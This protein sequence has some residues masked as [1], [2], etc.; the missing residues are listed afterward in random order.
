MSSNAV[1]SFGAYVREEQTACLTPDLSLLA[2]IY[3]C[4]TAIWSCSEGMV[5][6]RANPEG[7]QGSSLGSENGVNWSKSLTLLRMHSSFPNESHKTL[8]TF[9][10]SS[11]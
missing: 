6:G 7:Q 2:R 4:I 1:L 10:D 5:L 9:S 8:L 11:C 3:N